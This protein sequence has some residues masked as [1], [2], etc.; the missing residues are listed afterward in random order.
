M[1]PP[2][3]SSWTFFFPPCSSCNHSGGWSLRRAKR[4]SSPSVMVLFEPFEW[5]S[6]SSLKWILLVSFGAYIFWRQKIQRCFAFSRP[7][8][9]CAGA[10]LAEAGLQM[11]FDDFVIERNLVS[12]LRTN[13]V[14]RENSGREEYSRLQIAEKKN[15][16]KKIL[17]VS[18]HAQVLK[19]AVTLPYLLIT[20]I[21]STLLCKTAALD[22][23]VVWKLTVSGEKNQR[24]DGGEAHLFLQFFKFF[25]R[26]NWWGLPAVCLKCWGQEGGVHRMCSAVWLRGTYE[27]SKRR[28]KSP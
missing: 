21:I 19:T 3:E 13:E 1:N 23:F 9:C 14:N 2:R 17:S 28:K 8:C 16:R 7:L 15:C 5:T 24:T 25:W 12:C 4:L 20:A 26:L 27:V 18:E 6:R 22:F 10:R 11:A